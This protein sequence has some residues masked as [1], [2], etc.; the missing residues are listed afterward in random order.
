MDL[1]K[2]PTVRNNILERVKNLKNTGGSLSTVHTEKNL[3]PA[4]R[5][6]TARLCKT[7]KE[8]E[9]KT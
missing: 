4:V 7:E 5:K 1:H 6:E 9:N 2:Q 3:H 8:E